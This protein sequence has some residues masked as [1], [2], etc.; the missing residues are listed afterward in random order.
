MEARRPVVKFNSIRTLLAL[1]AQ[2][3]LDVHQMDVKAAYLNGDLDEEISN[4]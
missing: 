1:A 2:H 3:N 4:P